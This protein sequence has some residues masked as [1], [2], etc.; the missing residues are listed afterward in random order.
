M[1]NSKSIAVLPFVNTSNNP[2]NDYFSDGLTEEIINALTKIPGL[3][4]TARTSSF[5][6]KNIHKDIREIGAALNVALILEG[7][8]RMVK[9]NIRI[10]TQLIRSADGFNVWSETFNRQLTEIF[11]LQ[12]EISLLIADKIRENYGHLHVE[13]QLSNINTKNVEAYQHY[14]KGKEYYNQWNMPGFINAAASYE[15]S[16]AKDPTFDLPYFGAGLSYSFLGSWGTM[17]K[18]EAFKRVNHF[19]N[20]GNNLNIQSY[21]RYYSIAK[22]LFWGLWEFNKA[23]DS[24]YKAYQMMP[25]DAAVNEFMS[26]INALFGN[27]ITAKKYIDT[28]QQINPLSPTHY[29]TKA[30]ILFLQHQLKEAITVLEK[31]MLV[32]STFSISHELHMSCAIL[33]GDETKFK[34]ALKNFNSDLVELFTA[35]YQLV[36]HQKDFNDE[37]LQKAYA[38]KTTPLLAW[39]LYVLVQ[40]NKLNEALLLLQKKVDN[41]MGQVLYLKYDPWLKPLHGHETF[42]EIVRHN[43]P[44][45]NVPTTASG[46]NKSTKLTPEEAKQYAGKLYALMETDKMY[47]NPKLGLKELAKS[48]GLHPNK[49]SWLLNEAINKNFYEFV[50]NYRLKDFQQKALDENNKH[51]S[52]LGLA[53]ESGFNSKSV[54]NDF[55]KKAVGQT[56]KDWL[57]QQ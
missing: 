34:E 9:N 8:V 15:K 12:D 28:S 57:K 4:V 16:I 27:F 25:Q 41:R 33:L 36:N 39:D 23:Y 30:Q 7:S 26:E 17:N 40:Q 46:K 56:P 18:T 3:K 1:N 50:N 14:L 53:L 55:F 11:E 20:S 45:N 48:V 44:Q 42:R 43:G 32:A 52:I 6:F 37:L 38:A 2:E 51:L 5:A 22:H 10:T 24:L 54:F 13:E 21:F 31:G 47:L 35:I 19:F 49:L 29:Y